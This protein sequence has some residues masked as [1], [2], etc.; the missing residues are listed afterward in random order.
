M[1]ARLVGSFAALVLLLIPACCQPETGKGLRRE[2]EGQAPPAHLIGHDVIDTDK[3]GLISKAEIEGM[4][5]K[6][7]D[8]A[9]AIMMHTI[10]HDQD[11]FLTP[12][13]TERFMQIGAKEF[14]EIDTDGDGL[15]S[16]REAGAAMDMQL[17]KQLDKFFGNYDVEPKDGKVDNNA[18]KRRKIWEELLTPGLREAID[19]RATFDKKDKNGDHLHSRHEI[20]AAV[21]EED[22]LA[23]SE[24]MSADT[25][26]NGRISFHEFQKHLEEKGIRPPKGSTYREMFDEVDLDGS[27][28]HESSEVDAHIRRDFDERVSHILKDHD[29]NLDGAL[30]WEEY[31]HIERRLA[32]SIRRGPEL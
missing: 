11:G 28:N 10:D 20:G 25:D 19:K 24:A 23:H 22:A 31:V 16:A 30:D 1:A 4:L 3:D 18:F 9:L 32:R 21:N 14:E 29:L 15:H 6:Y 26:M 7:R 27:G 13:E 12:E 2:G 17:A 8:D 5:A